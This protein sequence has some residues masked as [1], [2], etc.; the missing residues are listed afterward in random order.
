[1]KNLTKC[2][3]NPARLKRPSA[4]WGWRRHQREDDTLA[5]PGPLPVPKDTVL[6]VLRLFGKVLSQRVMSVTMSGAAPL[7]SSR[8]A[9]PNFV[10]LVDGGSLVCFP[11][12]HPSGVPFLSLQEHVLHRCNTSPAAAVEARGILH[13]WLMPEVFMDV[14]KTSLSVT[15]GIQSLVKLLDLKCFHWG[16][17]LSK[18][19]TKQNPYSFICRKK[20]APGELLEGITESRIPSHSN[21]ATM[22]K[23]LLWGGSISSWDEGDPVGSCS[24]PRCPQGRLPLGTHLWACSG[25]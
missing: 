21:P 11:W 25:T 14:H 18:T 6:L 23:S 15:T 17:L 8:N 12:S 16:I 4:V 7:T 24:L 5:M 20:Y 1:M 22:L 9:P 13:S 19:E 2:L 10:M 3:E